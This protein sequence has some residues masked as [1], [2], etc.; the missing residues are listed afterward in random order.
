MI[1]P[2]LHLG[3]CCPVDIESDAPF[4]VR[5]TTNWRKEEGAW[6][7]IGTRI[8]GLH[9]CTGCDAYWP[10]IEEPDM[11]E[12]DNDEQGAAWWSAVG[13]FGSAFCPECGRLFLTQPDGTPE[14]YEV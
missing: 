11:W 2:S 12:C 10:C 8:N 14:C 3:E 5:L 1:D 6:W 9:L 4:V 13:W 7:E